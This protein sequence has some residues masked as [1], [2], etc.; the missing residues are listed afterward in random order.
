M[1]T[2]SAN[3]NRL[4]VSNRRCFEGGDRRP[5]DSLYDFLAWFSRYGRLT[6]TRTERPVD[7]ERLIAFVSQSRLTLYFR[8]SRLSRTLRR[9]TGVAVRLLGIRTN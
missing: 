5:A 3:M 7:T 1:A 6:P 4:I 2:G 8:T 9:Q